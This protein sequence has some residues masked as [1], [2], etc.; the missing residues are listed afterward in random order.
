MKTD[1]ALECLTVLAA[2]YPRA[3]IEEATLVAYSSMLADV[4]GDQAQAAIKRIICTSKWFPT[5]AE[6]RAEI[7]EAATAQLPAVEIAWGEVWKAIGKYGMY[8][9]P[10]FSCPEIAAA[11]D[12]IS[13]RHICLDENVTSTRARFT[14]AYRSIREGR[15]EAAQLGAHAPD[16]QQLP[17]R[18]GGQK[19]L[20][21]D[22]TNGA[23]KAGF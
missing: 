8:R 13:W 1:E 16:R 12:A 4:D 3:E 19:R 23:G 7:A 14:D 5:I 10:E 6:I 9:T 22:G 20:T 2:S 18:S 21:F 11:V 15:V 17:E